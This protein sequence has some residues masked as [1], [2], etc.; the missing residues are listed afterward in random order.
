MAP[1]SIHAPG[2][3]WE[4]SLISAD[5]PQD[6]SAPQSE[7]H[8]VDS[9]EE[10]EELLFSQAHLVQESVEALPFAIRRQ[11]SL[12]A[13]RGRR[14]LGN[15]VFMCENLLAQIPNGQL[16]QD[17]RGTGNTMGRWTNGGVLRKFNNTGTQIWCCPDLAS[18]ECYV[19]YRGNNIC[20][21]V[22][23]YVENSEQ[24]WLWIPMRVDIPATIAH[25][26][27]KIEFYNS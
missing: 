13:A 12:L 14:G 10:A 8:E 7:F 9:S 6:P 27:T 23:Q 22:A 11:S 25:Y 5:L 26:I 21:A 19:A 20:D 2:V 17:S 16:F 18:N 15:H 24:N 1:S 4:M 3:V